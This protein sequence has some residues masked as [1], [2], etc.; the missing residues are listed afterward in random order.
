VA[1]CAIFETDCGF[2]IHGLTGCNR[3][4]GKSFFIILCTIRMASAEC[5]AAKATGTIYCMKNPMLVGE[6][7]CKIGKTKQHVSKRLCNANSETFNFPEWRVEYAKEVDDVDAVEVKIH[8][9]LTALDTRMSPRREMFD[10]SLDI[11]KKIFDLVPGVYYTDTT[12]LPSASSASA[13]TGATT[14]AAAE[15]IINTDVAIAYVVKEEEPF[16]Y[17]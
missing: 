5:V 17:T 9:L 10:V 13:T 8:A 4:S 1:I 3:I 2:L 16:V 7:T 6:T 15:S 14:G 12:P 11:V